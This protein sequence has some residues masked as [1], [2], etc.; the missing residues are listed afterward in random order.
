MRLKLILS[1][2][3]SARRNKQ[4]FEALKY[5]YIY[6]YIYRERERERERKRKRKKERKK[7]R[8]RETFIIKVFRTIVFIFIVISTT[9]WSIFPLTFI[10]C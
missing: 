6:I 3:V 8:E 9:V 10:R 7:E 2:Y 1:N 4:L 5:I